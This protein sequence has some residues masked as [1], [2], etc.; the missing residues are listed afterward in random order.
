WGNR[1]ETAKKLKEK[2]T[3]VEST[4][5][6]PT[7]EVSVPEDVNDVYQQAVQEVRRK[8][9]KDVTIAT[10]QQKREDARKSFRTKKSV[11]DIYMGVIL[12]SVAGLAGF[13]FF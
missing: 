10:P 6:V 4:S 1:P 7:V 13:R 3:D 11:I 5:G 12:W 2:A 8:P 9:S